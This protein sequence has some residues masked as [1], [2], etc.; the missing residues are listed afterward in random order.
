MDGFL[1]SQGNGTALAYF[2]CKRDA[3]GP[4]DP[5]QVLRSIVRQLSSTRGAPDLQKPV[6]AAYEA[7]KENGAVLEIRESISLIISLVDINK[8]TTI[9]IDALDE[10]G[11]ASK[12]HEFLG[13]LKE[14]VDKSTSLVKVFVSSRNDTDIKSMFESKPNIEIE[15]KD[16]SEDIERFIEMEVTE[17]IEG[18][19]LLLGNVDED[20]KSLVISTLLEKAHGMYAPYNYLGVLVCIRW[21]L[22]TFL[23]GRV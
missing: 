8:H 22:L 14:L 11:E 19:R 23:R 12:R 4:S 6:I 10:C 2:Y 18:E 13:G 20:L 17:C 15:K 21:S 16:N 1:D 7:K 9:I 3:T 5:A